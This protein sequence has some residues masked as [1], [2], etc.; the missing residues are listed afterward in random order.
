[1][2]RRW[3]KRMRSVLRFSQ[4]GAR[5]RNPLAGY[6]PSHPAN[7]THFPT[8]AAVDVPRP[9][10]AAADHLPRCPGKRGSP[11]SGSG[12]Q[13]GADSTH[14]C[15]C[16]RIS[17]SPSTA[18]SR[19]PIRRVE[20][21]SPA[22]PMRPPHRAQNDFCQAL[23][24]VP[25]ADRVRA[26][27]D[28]ERAGV[29]DR[30]QRPQ[31]SAAALAALAVAVAGGV[32][33]RGDLE[34]VTAPHAHEP[35][36][37]LVLASGRWH[38]TDPSWRQPVAVGDRRRLGRDRTSSLERM[39]ETWTLA[40]FSAMNSSAPISRLVAP[41]AT[42][43]STWRSR[44]VRPNVSSSS[45]R[46]PPARRRPRRRPPAQPG[47]RGEALDLAAQPAGAEPHGDRVGRARRLRSRPRGRP[48][49]RAPRPR[50]SACAPPARGARPRPTRR[51][52]ARSRRVAGVRRRGRPRRAAPA[53]ART[54]P[55]R[56]RAAAAATR[57]Q[58]V[59]EAP[60]RR[61]LAS[62][63]PR[64]RAR[65]AA[66][67]S[68]VTPAAATAA[69]RATSSVQNSIRSSAVARP[70]RGRRR[71]RRRGVELGAQR[72]RR[73]EEL[74]LARVGGRSSISVEQRARVVVLAAAEGEL[75]APQA[76]VHARVPPVQRCGVGSLG[77]AAASHSPMSIAISACRRPATSS[78]S[79][80]RSLD[81][82][83]AL[84][85]TR[86][87]R[88]GGRRGAACPREFVYA[89][90]R[91]SRSSRSRAI[92]SP[93]AAPRRP[94]RPR[95]SRQAEPER[96]A[97]VAL[98]AHAGLDRGVERLRG[99]IV[100]A[101][102]EATVEHAPRARPA[103]RRARARRPRRGALDQRERPLERRDA[104]LRRG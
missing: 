12:S 99:A 4:P 70:P 27:D 61:R 96:V 40:V 6:A 65:S 16:G 87:P 23:G 39:R 29:D 44:G 3:A 48:R 31:R 89:S 53:A 104:R 28:P 56:V 51:P 20:S 68:T 82:R 50:A 18:P 8:S 62:A 102:T 21:G 37:G 38:G 85:V 25:G 66:S 36:S 1:M 15:H 83:A 7:D 9:A 52:R 46:R 79:A 35:V 98:G 24:R 95:R 86:A 92:R 77:S 72:A 26:F 42:S 76:E 32:E 73:P 67:A 47:P 84:G 41:P 19:M 57:E 54:R 80:A 34:P 88:R 58:Q 30:V 101:S 81:R 74:R 2:A 90:P 17:G 10:A 100:G 60:R 91:S 11:S 13:S 14:W 64:S 78:R 71:G 49:R 22:T 43:A 33:R 55:G 69:T 93:R 103:S 94:R 59:V 45:A 97:R 5:E 63:S 75:G